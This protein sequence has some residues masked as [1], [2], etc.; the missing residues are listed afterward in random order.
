MI[1]WIIFIIVS[2]CILMTGC[3][4]SY[5]SYYK[6]DENYLQRRQMETRYFETG[7]EENMLI[8]SAQVLQDLGYIISETDMK[9][10][11]ITGTKNREAGS[12]A[13]TAGAIIAGALFGFKPI[14][15]VSQK[16]YVTLVSTKSSI[17]N[18]YNIRVE[19]STII[20]NNQGGFRVERRLESEIYKDFFEKLSQSVFLTANYL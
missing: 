14:Y 2:A 16:I 6:L 3:S 13:Q 9:L 7:D 17:N 8:A 20:Y 11:V 19:F 5:D 12:A 4:V 10:G 15:D 1:K 18:G